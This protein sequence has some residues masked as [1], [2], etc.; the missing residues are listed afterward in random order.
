MIERTRLPKEPS[1]DARIAQ[2]LGNGRI[3]IDELHELLPQI[4]EAI[5]ES[6]KTARAERERSLD[7]SIPPGDA[8]Q[9]AQRASVAEFKRDRFKTAL[10]RIQQK[11]AEALKADYEDKWKAEAGKVTAQVAAA[12]AKL[13]GIGVTY[14]DLATKL[15]EALREAKALNQ[16]IDRI[17]VAAPDNIK[18]EQ[19]IA[20]A[21]LSVWDGL[22]LP[23]V[24]GE[25]GLLWPPPQP[26]KPSLAASYAAMITPVHDPA[27]SADWAKAREARAEAIRAEQQ[28]LADYYANQTRQQEARL[29]REERERFAQSQ[30][31][32]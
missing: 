1:L 27:Y 19:L 30:R 22:R 25:G 9:A 23:D 4:E 12:T 8:E 26:R 28:R 7:P 11:L 21:D 32:G 14:T 17:N 15:V 13:K 5:E 18:V 16:E 10:P 24:V 2:A 20:E 3:A 31:R 6:D 29:N